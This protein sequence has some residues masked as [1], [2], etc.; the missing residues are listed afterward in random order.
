[1]TACRPDEMGRRCAEHG[2]PLGADDRCESGRP[3][4]PIPMYLTCPRCSARHVDEGEFA[5][6]VHHTHSCQRCGLTW[7]PA[8]F[9]T[10]GVAFLPGFSNAPDVA[11]PETELAAARVEPRY[12]GAGSRAF[13]ERLNA[14]RGPAY[15]FL[16]V[17]AVSI[18]DIEVHL[19]RLLEDAEREQ[20]GGGR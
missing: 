6:R 11:L 7:R 19:F 9:A 16:Y 12:S 1:M 15:R 2:F 3:P 20:E 10:I 8:I 18:Q 17:L 14:V 13:W 4:K 5:T